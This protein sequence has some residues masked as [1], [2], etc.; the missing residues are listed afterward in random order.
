MAINA[1]NF[2][3]FNIF[4]IMMLINNYR[5]E[6]SNYLTLYKDPFGLFWFDTL[7]FVNSI[8]F[9][10][11]IES[12]T[13]RQLKQQRIHLV[14]KH[15]NDNEGSQT[16]RMLLEDQNMAN[17]SAKSPTWGEDGRT[18]KKVHKNHS[19]I[20]EDFHNQS[21]ESNELLLNEDSTINNNL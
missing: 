11:V 19:S 13:K 3:V 5:N 15:S 21:S 20:N 6:F 2:I 8:C 17:G 7:I 12:I 10:K 16:I 9:L 18:T 14:S 4:D 1:I